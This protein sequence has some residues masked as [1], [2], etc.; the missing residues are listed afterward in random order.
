MTNGIARMYK[1][2][3]I[4]NA[5][6]GSSDTFIQFSKSNSASKFLDSLLYNLQNN[7]L[8]AYKKNI[9]K[10]KIQYCIAFTEVPLLIGA[11]VCLWS[12]DSFSDWGGALALTN[13][14]RMLSDAGSCKILP[15][16]ALF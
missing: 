16:P 13:I 15:M 14:E 1:T 10:E 5:C 9:N 6:M 2:V 8:F 11:R 4:M 7:N 12:G 3:G